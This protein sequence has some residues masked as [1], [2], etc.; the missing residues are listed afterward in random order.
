MRLRNTLP[1]LLLLA[2]CATAPVVPS[3][4][5]PDA[6]RAAAATGVGDATV[7]AT[8]PPRR[9][10][11]GGG[12]YTRGKFGAFLPS[13]DLDPLD[14][15]IY[16]EIAIGTGLVPLVSADLSLGYLGADAG[17]ERQLRAAPL[18]VN[19]RIEVP[20]LVFEAY[21]GVGVGGMLADYDFRGVDDSEFVLASTAFAGLELGLGRLA[22]GGEYRYLTSEETDAGFTIEGHAL[23]VTATLPF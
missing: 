13:G 6:A 10:L 19:G 11:L 17:G 5:A 9:K 2:A 20:I 15:G 18:F 22:V 8:T 7:A 4:F 16:G 12:S 3:P 1:C 14:D 21:A 23:L